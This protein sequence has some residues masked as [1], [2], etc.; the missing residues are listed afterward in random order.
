MMRDDPRLDPVRA[1][2]L[3]EHLTEADGQGGVRLAADTAHR[4]VHPVLYRRGE[5]E[6]CWRRVCAP[7][8]W[9]T[10]SDP[11]WRRALGVSDAAYEAARA[12]FREFR[13]VAVA[14]SGH[15]LHHDQPERL[16]RIIEEFV[17]SETP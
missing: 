16:A 11:A 3:A 6:A 5:A 7:T 9:V 8:L 4:N 17:L 2:F 10:Q 15:N 12:C 1:S 13:E 14:D